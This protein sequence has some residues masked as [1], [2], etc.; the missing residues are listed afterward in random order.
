VKW[1]LKIWFGDMAPG[2]KGR[3]L[4]FVA[5]PWLAADVVTKC[6]ALGFLKKQ[7]VSFFSGGL[8]LL[9]RVNESLFSRGRTPSQVGVTNATA[10]WIVMSLGLSAVACYPFARAQWSVPRKLLLLLA[11]LLVGGMAGVLLG[12]RLDWDP[13]RLVL[14]AM[15]A[16]SATAILFLGLRLTRSRYLGLAIGLGLGGTLGNAINVLYYPRGVIDFIYVP[17]FSS[18]LGVFNLADVALE[19]AKGL[20]LLSPLMLVLFRRMGKGNPIWKPRLEYVNPVEPTATTPEPK[21]G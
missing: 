7:E 13:P 6:L 10:F 15:R 2:R 20:L 3:D 14:H 17:R 8:T 9:L 21:Q 16:F 5:L 18:Y 11:V 19:V 4:A 12:Y 1:L